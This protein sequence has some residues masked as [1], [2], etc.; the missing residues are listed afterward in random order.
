MYHWRSPHRRWNRCQCSQVTS[1]NIK[2]MCRKCPICLVDSWKQ[3]EG[4]HCRHSANKCSVFVNSSYYHHLTHLDTYS[5]VFRIE[6]MQT[7]AHSIIFI[8]VVYM[9]YRG[10]ETYF[11][12]W[13]GDNR[14]TPHSI[15]MP[16]YMV[17]SHYLRSYQVPTSRHSVILSP[18]CYL[19]NFLSLS[20]YY[21]PKCGVVAES[22]LHV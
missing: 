8:I 1:G 5:G 17:K 16:V 15:P 13:L 18:L 3:R 21:E 9:K 10:M 12:S 6:Q 22:P 20:I 4:S 14:V 2:W 7:Y 11:A 19:D